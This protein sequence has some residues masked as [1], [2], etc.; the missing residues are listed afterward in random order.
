MNT[1]THLLAA[2]SPVVWT[3]EANQPVL[4]AITFMAEK[5]IGALLVT[6]DTKLVG[7]MSERD[8]ARKVILRNKSSRETMV[9]EIMSSNVISVGPD[10]TITKCMELMTDNKVRHLPVLENDRITGV[11]SMSDLVRAIIADQQQT[12]QHLE[13]YIM[14]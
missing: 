12:I 14:S 3:I 9:S 7:I 10:D 6:D 1:V 13:G 5:E 4:N 2:K 11:L 8:Y